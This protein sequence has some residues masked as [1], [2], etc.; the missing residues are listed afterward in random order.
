MKQYIAAAMFAASF[1]AGCQDGQTT[2]L[3]AMPMGVRPG[4][5][6]SPKLLL[7]DDGTLFLHPT[8][9]KDSE[10]GE[11]EFRTAADGKYR[12]LPVA[13]T[14]EAMLYIDTGCTQPAYYHPVNSCTPP[15]LN[16]LVHR[17]GKDVCDHEGT[18]SV[19]TPKTTI[20]KGTLFQWNESAKTCSPF[21]DVN[22]PD[23]GYIVLF[24]EEIPA[25]EFVSA[26]R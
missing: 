13:T 26:W 3:D 7:A 23:T 10:F 9:W 4:T 12:C 5:R 8:I 11:C 6:L 20:N 1:L 16:I 25:S 22:G 17:Q 19:F 24:D 2:A 14:Q 21:V 15:T 18:W